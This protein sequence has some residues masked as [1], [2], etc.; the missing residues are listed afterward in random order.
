MKLRGLLAV[1]LGVLAAFAAGAAGLTLTK[2]EQ[3]AAAIVLAE[4]PTT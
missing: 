1:C 2:A 3:P 4:K